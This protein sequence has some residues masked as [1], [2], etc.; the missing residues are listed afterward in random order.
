MATTPKKSGYW[1]EKDQK[2]KI[3]KIKNWQ[4][5]ARCKTLNKGGGESVHGD[6]DALQVN[7]QMV[8]VFRREVSKIRRVEQAVVVLCVDA[9]NVTGTLLRTIRNYIGG[10]PILL[11]VTRCDLLP[12]YVWEEN[13]KDMMR[14]V[15]SHRARELNPA[16]VYLCS[17]PLNADNT[18]DTWGVDALA[19]DLFEYLNGRDTYVIGA[20]NLGK[21]TLTDMLVFSLMKRGVK[22]GLFKGR[23]ER[24]RM[25][26]LREARVTKSALPGTTLQNVRVPCFGDHM[27]ALW[28][29][30]GLVLDHSQHHFPIRNIQQL[31]RKRPTQIQ[32]L[33]FEVTTNSFALLICEKGEEMPLLRF[34][35]RLRKDGVNPDGEPVRLAWNS[36]F[37]LEAKVMDIAEA[38]N[39]EKERRSLWES[40]VE[41]R[42]FERQK[43]QTVAEEAE[44]QP[45]ERD[46]PLTEEE[47]AQRK[48]EKRRAYEQRIQEE[49]KE[50]GNAEWRRREKEQNAQWAEERRFK[51]LAEL[52]EVAELICD[53]GFGTDI[54]VANFGWLGLLAP[55]QIKV[56]AFAPS[57]G[58]QISSHPTLALPSSWGGFKRVSM[59]EGK[60][61]YDDDNDE[62]GDNNNDED[63]DD[64]DDYSDDFDSV[65]DNGWGFEEE[66][67]ISTHRPSFGDH[68]DGEE[69]FQK[70]RY[71]KLRRRTK[72][73]PWEMYSGVHVGWQ[74]DAD[75]RW[76]KGTKLQEGWNPVRAPE[77]E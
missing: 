18:E 6:I 62:D 55:V 51:S 75:L 15:F 65:D 46:R 50:L 40:Q 56:V 19:N 69:E 22:A 61:E 58:V 48:A 11:A 17:I 35:V 38:R 52:P 71:T 29:T 37:P 42:A 54:C 60:E 25:E 33:E 13:D 32:P 10:N 45:N 68:Y 2:L 53:G 63:G 9:S 30:P 49:K 24:K 34:E 14:Q 77:K 41:E 3:S 7:S 27:Q 12:D 20:A 59:D 66:D 64:D 23:L 44:E 1:A 36:T 8:E 47:R 4:L 72:P 16:D 39:A 57:T 5:C 73:D 43:Q 74:F 70:E 31:L 28:D 21:S 67:Y 26:K 76:S